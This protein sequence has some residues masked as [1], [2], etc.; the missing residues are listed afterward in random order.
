VSR[1]ERDSTLER[2][3]VLAVGVSLLAVVLLLV[4]PFLKRSV[5]D[6]SRTVAVVG[7]HRITRAE[8]DK[9]QKLDDLG[10]T[11]PATI[12]SAYAAYAQN[13]AGFRSQ[14][15]EQFGEES[16]AIGGVDPT[17]LQSMVNREVLVQA[18]PSVGVQVSDQEVEKKLDQYLATP[19]PPGAPGVPGAPVATPTAG[20]VAT[21]AAAPAQ[22]GAFFETLGD[23]VRIGRADY[24]RLAVRPALVEERYKEKVVPQATE[25]AHVRHILVRTEAE[26]R[27]VLADLRGGARFEVLARERSIDE[28]TKLKGGDLGWSP[29]ETYVEEFAQAAFALRQPGQLS[30]PV[31]SNFGYHI[32]QLIQRA[33]NRPLT[34]AQRESLGQAKVSQYV[35]DQRKALEAQNRL[36]VTV[37]PTPQP[38]PGAD[39]DATPASP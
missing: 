34:P 7:D 9:R 5:W 23:T 3:L 20:P 30:P 31:K 22:A 6:P 29:R 27:K 37:A 14:L 17:S 2:L 28:G 16:A 19:E 21:P 25:Q 12:G 35:L 4:V 32:I 13:P 24:A 26:A 33:D 1:Y 11:N 38:T 8:Y 18:A 15:E 39:V 36:T 10:I